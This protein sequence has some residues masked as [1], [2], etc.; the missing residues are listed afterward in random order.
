VQ[1]ESIRALVQI[2]SEDA[3]AVLEHALVATGTARETILQQLIGLRDDK[4]APLLCH[5]LNHSAP[6]GRLVDVH[7]RIID[8][9]GHLKASAE[10]T[11]TLRTILHR[12]EW[13]AP[14]RTSALRQAAAAA[15]GRIGAPETLAVLDEAVSGGSR[16]VRN[17]AR[18][19]AAG[20]VRRERERA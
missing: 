6:R 17:A 8:A 1:R 14:F 10:S 20:A 11:R 16:G 9:L 2:G 3:Y 18:P 15:L 5:V 13:W 4:A 7:T 12:G 19:H